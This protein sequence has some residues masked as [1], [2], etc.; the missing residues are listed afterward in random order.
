MA[1][2]GCP[3]RAVRHLRTTLRG[4]SNPWHLGVPSVA[5]LSPVDPCFPSSP[6]A[7]APENAG[8]VDLRANVEVQPT[9]E[10]P[11]RLG[12]IFASKGLP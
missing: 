3:L 10:N 11:R 5:Y 12:H 9:V 4:A 2:R 6:G 7:L 1:A 8:S